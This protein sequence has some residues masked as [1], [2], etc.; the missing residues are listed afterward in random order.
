MQLAE[1]AKTNPEPWTAFEWKY[2][3]SDLAWDDCYACLNFLNPNK[4][5]RRKGSEE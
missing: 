1:E 4:K 3:H 2:T 5:F